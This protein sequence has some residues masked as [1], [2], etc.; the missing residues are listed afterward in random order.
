MTIK[1]KRRPQIAVAVSTRRRPAVAPLAEPIPPI[2]VKTPGIC[3]GK[4][5]IAGTRIPVWG[6]ENSRRLGFTDSEIIKSYP[7]VTRQDLSA[8]WAYVAKHPREIERQI[9]ANNEG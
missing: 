1:A 5:R 7:M 2:V 6:V 9:A 4:A 8:A 3:G